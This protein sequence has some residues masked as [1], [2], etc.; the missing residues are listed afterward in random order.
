MSNSIFISEEDLATIQNMAACNY[1][2][3]EIALQLGVKK[4]SFLA[5]FHE[6]ESEV[7]QAY[8]SGKLS[9]TF[10]IM[11][12]QKELAEGGNITAAQ[13]FLKESERIEFEN[14]KRKI[15]FDA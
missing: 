5:L 8:D 15:F 10:A 11:G 14:W 7:R 9:T 3:S 4:K 2:P 12:K 1:G 13:I 6:Q